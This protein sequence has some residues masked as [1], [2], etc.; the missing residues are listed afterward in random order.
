M[1]RG[2]H[3]GLPVAIDRAVVLPFEYRNPAEDTPQAGTRGPVRSLSPS[4]MS[5]RRSFASSMMH[6]MRVGIGTASGNGQNGGPGDRM[7]PISGAN[8]EK[9]GLSLPGTE[10]EPERRR[11]SPS[12]FSGLGNGL[13]ADGMTGGLSSSN[14]VVEEE[15]SEKEKKS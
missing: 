8:G 12:R 7:S 14:G 1:L 6:E 5:R 3:R 13:W 2:R 15:L 9:D 11:R 10:N 4:R